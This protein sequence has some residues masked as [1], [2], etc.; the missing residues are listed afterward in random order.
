MTNSTLI[1]KDGTEHIGHVWKVRRAEGFITII[2][3]PDGPTRFEIDDIESLYTPEENTRPG[4]PA[5]Y[6]IRDGEWV[7][8]GWGE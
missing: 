3:G 4:Q 8:R 5:H 7:A 6:W 2:I 1:L